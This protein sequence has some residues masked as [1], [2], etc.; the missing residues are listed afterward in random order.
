MDLAVPPT[1]GARPGHDRTAH[2]SM[3][4]VLK[5]RCS[6]ASLLSEYQQYFATV[7]R[8]TPSLRAIAALG[9][10][11]AS[12][13]RISCLVSR[14]TVILPL[15]PWAPSRQRWAPRGNVG[16][17]RAPARGTRPRICELCSLLGARD[18]QITMRI[19]HNSYCTS[20][21]I[22]TP[23]DARTA[24]PSPLGARG[25]L[26]QDRRPV[27]HGGR[28]RRCRRPGRMGSCEGQGPV[29]STSRRARGPDDSRAEGFLGRLEVGSL[30]GRDRNGVPVEGSV[31]GL[32]ACLVWCRDTRPEGDPGYRGPM[33]HREGPGL[34]AQEVGPDLPPHAL[35]LKSC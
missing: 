26:G 30:F 29:R 20:T 31:A 2:F 23:P 25:R 14:G 35:V 27:I 5:S 15:L 28:G 16:R 9:T 6:S 3:T 34:A 24:N 21:P 1:P 17:G 12:I 8:L 22:S 32:G 10:P 7:L 18:A 11:P 33:Q 13:S 19:R 4:T